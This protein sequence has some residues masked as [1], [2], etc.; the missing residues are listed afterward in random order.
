MF[1]LTKWGWV[2]YVFLDDRWRIEPARQD[3][4]GV[5]VIAVSGRWPSKDEVE[6]RANS[7]NRPRHLRTE[8]LRF[9]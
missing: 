3:S 6:Y 7:A 5:L 4:P 9:Q 2:A 8:R 1:I